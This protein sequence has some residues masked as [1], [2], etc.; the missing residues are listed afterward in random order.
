M[1][2]FHH[3][4]SPLLKSDNGKIKSD[5]KSMGFGYSR[6]TA[7][8]TSHYGAVHRQSS[9]LLPSQ[10][11]NL[12]TKNPLLKTNFTIMTSDF[13][14][15]GSISLVQPLSLPNDPQMFEDN[16]LGGLHIWINPCRTCGWNLLSQ[17]GSGSFKEHD[18]LILSSSLSKWQAAKIPEEQISP[19]RTQASFT[20]IQMPACEMFLG[21]IAGNISKNGFYLVWQNRYQLQGFQ[22]S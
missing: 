17:K 13:E 14:S 10:P 6:E 15:M 8:G 12:E 2:I 5:L 4:Q 19:C 22:K 9:Q 18:M 1:L 7:I 16:G 11:P 3:T 21:R 20:T